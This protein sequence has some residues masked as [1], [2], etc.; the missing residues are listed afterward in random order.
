M[1]LHCYKCLRPGLLPVQGFPA[2]PLGSL[3]ACPRCEIL[4]PREK[5]LVTPEAKDYE[6]EEADRRAIDALIKEVEGEGNT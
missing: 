6:D 3:W 2:I 5:V 4:V 1:R